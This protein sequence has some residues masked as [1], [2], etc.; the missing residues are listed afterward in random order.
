MSVY[1]GAKAFDDAFAYALAAE[2]APH[3]IDVTSILPG[4][5]IFW[6]LGRFVNQSAV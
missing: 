6:C 2:L 5:G 3:K 1:A 4:Y